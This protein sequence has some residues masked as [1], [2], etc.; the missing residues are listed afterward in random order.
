MLGWQ[1]FS[2]SS[3]VVAISRSPR[4]KHVDDEEVQANDL[5]EYLEDGI[6]ARARGIYDYKMVD[7]GYTYVYTGWTTKRGQLRLFYC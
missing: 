2:W 4:S 7:E 1:L 6:R 5:D 3:Q